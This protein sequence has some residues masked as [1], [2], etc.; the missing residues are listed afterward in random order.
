MINPLEELRLSEALAKC[1]LVI[2]G[3]DASLNVYPKMLAD[4]YFYLLL[5]FD[6]MRLVLHF[7]VAGSMFFQHTP[8]GQAG[9][10][11]FAN[12]TFRIIFLAYQR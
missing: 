10:F 11:I 2:S 4:C 1:K 6:F 3:C 7:P 8:K 5:Q 9:C 12:H